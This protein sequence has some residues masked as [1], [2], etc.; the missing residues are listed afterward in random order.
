MSRRERSSLDLR[1]LVL[2]LAAGLFEFPVIA[3]MTGWRLPIPWH[4]GFVM[5]CASAALV[6]LAPPPGRGYFQPT[7]HWG[8]SLG[9]I[10]LLV[11]GAGWAAAG[12]LVLDNPKAPYDKDA[13]IFEDHSDEDDGPA[14]AIG[15]S[16]AI[17]ADLADAQD[18]IPAVDALLSGSSALK[19]GA[20]E[21]LAKIQTSEAIGWIQKART[22]SDPEVRFYA[23]TALTRLKHEFE[24]AIHAAERE[25]FAAPSELKPQIS[26]QRVRY[27]YAVSGML[28]PDAKTTVLEECR[29][30][31][32]AIA[33]RYEDAARLLYLVEKHLDPER[34]FAVLD[35]L[36]DF[37][38]ER[39]ARWVRERAELLFSLGRMGEVKS[40]LRERR[41]E[42]EDAGESYPE[43]REWRT[44]FLW[45]AD[46]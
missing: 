44:A 16:N 1:F 46:D 20:I 3:L 41:R 12:W 28:E 8:E 4:V 27:E 2:W 21:T 39:R 42:M 9:L 17:A 6:F 32:S 34:A 38:P 29:K 40:L 18:V 7:R 15:E 33:Q 23:T 43:D 35:R 26:L 19:R 37:A 25:V 10:A 14:S 45:W 11:P 13:Y 30:R 36:E 31:L 24:T 22:E 5:H